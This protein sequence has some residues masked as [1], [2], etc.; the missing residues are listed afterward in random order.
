MTA[1]Q[2]Q[3]FSLHVGR[4]PELDAG[5]FISIPRE[6]S[7]GDI[8][9]HIRLPGGSYAVSIS[10]DDGT[11]C[12]ASVNAAPMEVN[13][14]VSVRWKPLPTGSGYKATLWKQTERVMTKIRGSEAFNTF[15]T[16]KCTKVTDFSF[17][18]S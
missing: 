16:T 14:Q 1:D 12:Y 18:V 4:S 3:L 10:A 2:M 11:L 17:T 15:I 9:T 5:N 6:K 13:G 8:R 7:L